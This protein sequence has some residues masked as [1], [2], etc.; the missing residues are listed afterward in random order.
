[1]KVLKKSYQRPNAMK[2]R[3]LFDKLLIATHNE[4]KLREFSDIF[5]PY[6]TKVLSAGQLGLA[7]PEETGD[8]FTANALLKARA[9]VKAATMP[10]LADDSGLCVTA[11]GGKPGL[12]SARWGGPQK[13]FRLAMQR[14][15]E[16]LGDAVDRSAYFVCVLA[17]VWPDGA[18]EVFEGR[19]DGTLIWPPR[20]EKGH[21]Y[22][23]FF[24]PAGYTQTFAELDAESKNNLS[25]RGAALKKMMARLS[26]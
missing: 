18:E 11:L 9:A 15:H 14:V 17:L 25:H 19:C 10:A 23:P 4:G 3:F 8:S 7:E 24:V 1:M 12:Y 26:M 20:G 13:D 21:G 22:D 2:N 5:A 6:G 16:E